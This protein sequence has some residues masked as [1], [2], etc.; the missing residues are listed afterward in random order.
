MITSRFGKTA[1][2]RPE[3][4]ISDTSSVLSYIE[5]VQWVFVDEGCFGGSCDHERVQ[6]DGLD[7][8]RVLD[9]RYIWRSVNV[10]VI[11]R[12]FIDRD[13]LGSSCDHERVWR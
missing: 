4:W 7:E 9:K 11:N 3:C 6:R 2:M 1:L 10:E 12:V 5:V 8:T 13:C